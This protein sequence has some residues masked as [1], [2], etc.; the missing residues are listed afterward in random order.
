MTMLIIASITNKQINQSISS[1]LFGSEKLF[2]HV[3]SKL[4]C[5]IDYF[6]LRIIIIIIIF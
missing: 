3:Q 6:L 4:V 2:F 5:H 1:E